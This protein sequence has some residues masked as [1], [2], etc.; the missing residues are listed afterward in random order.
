[1]SKSDSLFSV[2]FR[3]GHVDPGF[4]A[5][6]FFFSVFS[7][8]SSIPRFLLRFF[9]FHFLRSWGV[10]DF[11]FVLFL[12]VFPDS[13]I[14]ASKQV[15]FLH[16]VGGRFLVCWHGAAGVKLRHGRHDGSVDSSA[17]DQAAGGS[18]GESNRRG[19]DY[20]KARVRAQGASR[21]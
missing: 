17:P 18:S 7:S 8:F 20:S 6:F 5:S 4:T 9:S 19:R 2:H 11:C 1:M 10:W 14:S 16:G 21:E 13:E 3:F 15:K 12:F